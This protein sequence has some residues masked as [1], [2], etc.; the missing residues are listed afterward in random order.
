MGEEK[1]RISPKKVR[2]ILVTTSVTFSSDAIELAVENNIDVVFMNTFGRAFARI[3]HGK[4]GS[5]ARIRRVQLEKTLSSEGVEIGKNFILQK[6][7]N[8]IKFLTDLRQRR[9]RDSSEITQAIE[10]IKSSSDALTI[11]EG[12]V[13]EA[14]G[15]IMGIEGSAAKVYWSVLSLLLPERF[16]FAG[17]SRNPAQDEFNCLLNYSYGVL[18]GIIERACVIAGIDPYVGFIHSDHYAKTSM[19]FDVIE[20]YRIYADETVFNLFSRKKVRQVLFDKLK[21]GF[22]L[23]KE[24]KVVLLSDFNEYLDTAI[25]Y[26]GR[27]I[28]R[29]DTVQFDLH[30]LANAWI[31]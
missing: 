21:N 25:L 3:W 5:T 22:V 28:K 2:S 16:Q 7:S 20:G 31:A 26:N 14:R 24:G 18:Y 10:T 29:R 17:R 6:F 19:V 4:L 1:K 8:Q 23:N 13:E 12:Q 15:T 11:V 9:T 27:K 30:K